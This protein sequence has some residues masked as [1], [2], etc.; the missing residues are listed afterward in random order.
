MTGHQCPFCPGQ[1]D[2]A[3]QRT[4][5]DHYL[6]FCST[7]DGTWSYDLATGALVCINTGRSPRFA[8]NGGGGVYRV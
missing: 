8:A 4:S 6:R 1:P 2:T 5:A 7:C 3:A